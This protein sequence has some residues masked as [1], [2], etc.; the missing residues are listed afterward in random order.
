MILAVF[1]FL[2]SSKVESEHVDNLLVIGPI[3]AFNSWK[4]EF[5]QVFGNKKQLEVIDCQS[6][7]NFDFDLSGTGKRSNLV[8]VNYES[9]TKIQRQVAGIAVN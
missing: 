7:K 3:N 6:S 2:N 9:L 4:E 8:L 1:A 5:K